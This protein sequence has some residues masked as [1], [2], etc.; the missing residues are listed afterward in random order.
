MWILYQMYCDAYSVTW[1]IILS[2]CVLLKIKSGFIPL[3]W[4]FFPAIGNILRLNFFYKWRGI[5][6]SLIISI[7]IIKR[8]FIKRY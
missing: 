2:L 7:F 4:V 5:N 1:M 8:Y 6:L 3:H